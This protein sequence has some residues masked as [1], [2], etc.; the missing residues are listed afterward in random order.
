MKNY[1]NKASL[2]LQNIPSIDEIIVKFSHLLIP[3]KY[4]KYKLNLELDSIR[5]EIFEGKEFDDVN[6]YIN[7]R[8]LTLVN[9]ISNNSLRS[10]INGTGII[11]HTGLGRAP[12]SKDI[13][14]DGINRTYPYSNL[15]FNLH[16]GGRDNRNNHISDLLNSL[17]LSEKAI[18]VNNNASAVMLMI[19]SICEDKE[20]II[21]RGQLVEIGGAFRIP[22]VIKKSQAQMVEVGTTN[23][24]YLKDFED[25][26]TGDSKKDMHKP[27]MFYDTATG[28]KYLLR[29]TAS[30][31]V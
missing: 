10:V 7:D 5:Q 17:C 23:K 21:S 12:I 25:N 27:I 28:E 9:N 29:E 20:I 26:K 2:V 18:V 24:T 11:L 31:P 13:L 6:K 14:I 3:P 8:I 15:E 22:D 16:S 4:L 1:K 19:N 30:R